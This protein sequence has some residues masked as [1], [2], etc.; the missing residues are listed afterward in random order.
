MNHLYHIMMIL[1]LNEA[2][3]KVHSSA[4]CSL[5]VAADS[6]TSIPFYAYASLVILLI[7]MLADCFML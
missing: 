2:L 5:K 6:E 1:R 3:K 4:S 7:C